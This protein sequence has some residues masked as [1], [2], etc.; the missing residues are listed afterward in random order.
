L[1]PPLAATLFAG[2]LGKLDRTRQLYRRVFT[3]LGQ[4]SISEPFI[5]LDQRDGLQWLTGLE[6]RVT[7][8]SEKLAMLILLR[9][10]TV[11]TCPMTPGTSWFRI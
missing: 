1:L 8:P 9:P 2:L 6:R 4:H 10:R 5:R 7:P 3:E 11:P